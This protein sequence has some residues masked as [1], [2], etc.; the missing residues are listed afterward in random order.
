MSHYFDPSRQEN[1]STGNKDLFK[2]LL[3]AAVLNS[4]PNKSP[5]TIF[6]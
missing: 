3:K 6:P 1:P 4:E 5:Q 2:I